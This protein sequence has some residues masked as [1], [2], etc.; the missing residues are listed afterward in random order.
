MMVSGVVADSRRVQPGSL[1]VAYRGLEVDGHRYIGAALA[2]GAAALVVERE[3]DI[4]TAVPTALVPDAR[5]AW[6]RLSAAWEEFPARQLLLA[7]VTGTD[8][9]TTTAALLQHILQQSGLPTG[10][11]STV[12]ALVGGRPLDTGLHTTTP[13]PSD[14]QH[15]LRRM[16]DSGSRAAV[17][18]AT[19]E[20]LAQ[21]RLDGCDFDLAIVTNITHDHLY[22]HGSLA[23]YREAKATL[24]RSLAS[25]YR[26]PG[27]AKVAVLNRDDSSF[28]Y[29]VGI[30]ADR[31]ISYGSYGSSQGD[32][33]VRVLQ[34]ARGQ[35]LLAFD[36]PWGHGEARLPMGGQY[37]AYNAA[38][39]IAGACAWGI[40]LDQA[41]HAMESFPGVPG[42]NEFINQGQPF[43]VVVDFAHTANA[44]EQ[45][46][47]AARAWTV[48]RLIVVF[49]C[50]GERDRLKRGPMGSIA[51][52]LADLAIFTA[53]D[54]RREPLQ[55]ILAEMEA[56]AREAG[57]LLG[58]HYLIEPD[59]AQAI[60][61]AISQAA[62][63]DTV[64]IC[65]KGHEQS[66]CYGQEE[67]PW[68][69][70]QAAREAL[71]RCGFAPGL[72]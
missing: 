17:V 2:S 72:P 54:P 59:R 68:D 27:V 33:R 53:E 21:K 63:G 28:D 43:A 62:P 25:S 23:A 38:A 67:R 56:G 60:G 64:L 7:G 69:D 45:A 42:R 22:F 49:G 46:L 9:K 12:N 15:L 41:C 18:E 29:L 1:F 32:V 16:V 11:I 70:R 39:A 47:R 58:R 34:A 5:S 61:L 51:V 66:M 71:R 20:G 26:K 57:G 44:L 4:P 48:G 50:A 6:A 65:G 13:P 36:S 30:P 10:L 31:T 52:Q 14:I 19:S 40:G 3:P 8:G 35:L 55:A 24:F 37:N